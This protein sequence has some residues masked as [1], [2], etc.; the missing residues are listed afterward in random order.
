VKFEDYD[1]DKNILKFKVF[2]FTIYDF[3]HYNDEKNEEDEDDE[4]D[5]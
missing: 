4:D 5:E 3:S 2:H 1:D